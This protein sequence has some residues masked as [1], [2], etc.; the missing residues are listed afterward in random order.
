MCRGTEGNN[1][2][3]KPDSVIQTQNNEQQKNKN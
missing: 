2:I 1:S 3:V